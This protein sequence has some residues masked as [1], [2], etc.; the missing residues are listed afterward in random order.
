M[1]KLN[2]S[3]ITKK[4]EKF[5]LDAEE[6]EIL[7]AFESG[8]YTVAENVAQEIAKAKEAARNS[9]HKDI[10]IN[11]RLSSVDLEHIKQKAAYEGMPYQ[12]L[13]A[14]ILHKF[15]AGHLHLHQ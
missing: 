13:I 1:K 2:E 7:H 15:A 12:T 4:T 8:T 3:K 10:R 9:L 14:S 11:L 6:K 5:Q